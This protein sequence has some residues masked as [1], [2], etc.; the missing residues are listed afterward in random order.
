MMLIP[1]LPLK[2]CSE[3]FSAAQIIRSACDIWVVPSVCG[4]ID[5]VL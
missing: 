5:S 3:N 2:R 1:S 4:V